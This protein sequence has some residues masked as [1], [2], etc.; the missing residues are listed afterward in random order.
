MIS[1][2]VSLVWIIALALLWREAKPLLQRKVSLAE[3]R[4][5]VEENRVEVERQALLRPPIKDEDPMPADFVT[6]AM[7]ES[8]EWAREDKL[9]RMRE[10][11][12]R[13]GDWNKVRQALMAEEDIS[14]KSTF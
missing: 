14:L 1:L 8:S 9:T 11:H 3:R 7:Q 13:L 12:Q 6:W 2:S 5:M 10:L 4:V